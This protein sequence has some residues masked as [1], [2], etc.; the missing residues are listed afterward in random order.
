MKRTISEGFHSIAISLMSP[1]G[2]L[3]RS[4]L[5][6]A[7]EA[8]KEPLPAVDVSAIL[9]H[10]HSANTPHYTEWLKVIQKSPAD[11]TSSNVLAPSVYCGRSAKASDLE[12]E[13]CT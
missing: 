10:A 6:Q 4:L 13:C 3:L 11:F 5:R 12:V 1:T 2:I 9:R 7:I 8:P